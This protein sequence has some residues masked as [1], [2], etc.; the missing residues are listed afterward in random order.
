MAIILRSF[1]PDMRVAAIHDIDLIDLYHR[2]IRGLIIDL[3]NTLVSAHTAEAPPH[4]RAWIER[5]HAAG[6]RVLVLSNNDR[7]RVARFAEPLHIP[8]VYK[9]RKPM[10]SA[11]RRAVSFLKMPRSAVAVIGDQMM[12]D[13]W[14]AKRCGLYAIQVDPIAKNEDAFFTRVV[15]R[16]LE[17][18]IEKFFLRR[19]KM[20]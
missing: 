7:M 9:A 8:F 12:T 14:G 17:R 15:N 4:I 10:G 11:F 16:S 20:R 6:M 5:V 18:V 2:G 13:V 3:D 19:R 1:V